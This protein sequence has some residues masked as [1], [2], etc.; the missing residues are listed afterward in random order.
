VFNKD[1]LTRYREPYFTG[2]YMKLTPLLYIINEEEEYEVK[3]IKKHRRR[4]QRT[5]YLVQWKGYRDKH[6]Q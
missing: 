3:E 1:L 4:E 2:Q 6:D 5:Q